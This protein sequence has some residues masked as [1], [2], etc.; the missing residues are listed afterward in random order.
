MR[1]ILFLCLILSTAVSAQDQHHGHHD[2]QMDSSGMVMNANRDLLPRGCQEIS[3]DYHFSISA[4]IQFAAGS[5][6]M[7]FGMSQHELKVE[8]CSRVTVTFTNADEVRHQWMVHGLPKYLYPTGMF[9]IEAN[10]GATLTGT[11]IVPGDDRTYL[12]HCDMAQH[13]EKGMKGQ[14]VVGAGSGNLWSV[15]DIGDP[16]Y[17]DAYLPAYAWLLLVLAGLAGLA[18]TLK[19]SPITPG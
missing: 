9:H 6:G 10:A 4:G 16:F 13:M 19:F 8:P 18:A 11:F 15:K 1:S 17:R 3:R 7:I 14:L 5:P 2:M 12:I